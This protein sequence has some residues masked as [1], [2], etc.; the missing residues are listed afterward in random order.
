LNS[1]PN[2]KYFGACTWHIMTIDFPKNVSHV[3]DYE[4]LKEFV[5]GKLM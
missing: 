4:N 3:A 5:Y 1:L 2:V